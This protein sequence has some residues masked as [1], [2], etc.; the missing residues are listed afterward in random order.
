[1]IDHGRP[2]QIATLEEAQTQFATWRSN[3]HR[4]RRIPDKLWDAAV[5]LCG[6]HSVCKVSRALGLDYKAL[7]LRCRGSESPQP[8]QPFVELPGLWNSGEV[9]VECDDGQRRHLRI[10]CKGH[11]DSRLVDVVRAFFE[12]RR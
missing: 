9:L 11:V 3:P 4:G 8:P 7:R 6:A 12:G 2:V 1:M 10:H 5:R